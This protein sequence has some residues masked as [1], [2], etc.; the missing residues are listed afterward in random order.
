[1]F[2][3]QILPPFV[4]PTCVKPLY[5]FTGHEVSCNPIIAYVKLSIGT[6][7][8]LSQGR[9]LRRSHSKGISDLANNFLKSSTVPL[10][11]SA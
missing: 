6:W 8:G 4:R 10:A 1:M 3:A 9:H 11:S 7:S 5:E 2:D